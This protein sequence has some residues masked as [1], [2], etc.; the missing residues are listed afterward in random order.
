VVFIIEDT[1]SGLETSALRDRA[2]AP[3]LLTALTVF[4]AFSG[5][6]KKFT[7]MLAPLSANKR[8]VSLPM[9]P[10]APVMITDLPPNVMFATLASLSLRN[11]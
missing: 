10:L 2:S 7:V 1:S 8:A 4:F 3:R 6:E 11:S 9:P 5:E